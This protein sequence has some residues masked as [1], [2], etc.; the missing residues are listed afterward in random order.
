MVDRLAPDTSVAFQQ[1]CPK[2]AG[3][4]SHWR[5]EKYKNAV[6]VG[7]ALREGAW[8]GDLQN[9]FKAGYLVIADRALAESLKKNLENR[10]KAIKE[11][12]AANKRARKETSTAT[13]HVQMAGGADV[14]VEAQLSDLVS[15][16]KG[17]ACAAMAAKTG[18][19][20]RP[21]QTRLL[22]DSTVLNDGAALCNIGVGPDSVLDLVVLPRVQVTRHVYEAIARPAFRGSYLIATDEIELDANERLCD[23]WH[24]LVP[25]D[26]YPR[27]VDRREGEVVAFPR[28]AN[29]SAP[30]KWKGGHAVVD[31]SM[32]A[33]GL[34]GA[35]DMDVAVFVP[36]PAAD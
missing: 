33:A 25:A 7:E 36:M 12:S 11:N 1:I 19:V 4:K 27:P 16:F 15:V 23:Q 21:N 18:N 35:G 24:D 8:K 22:H 26:G 28:T 13:L 20:L 6:T 34:F 9:D 17:T 3:C 5:Y 10:S 29:G 32:T 31:R 2:K 30:K 14:T